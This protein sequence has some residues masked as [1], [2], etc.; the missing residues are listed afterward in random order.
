MIRIGSLF[1]GAGGLD[2]AVEALF[3][4]CHVVWQAEIDPHA[5]K[6]LAAHY[7][8]VPNL[9]DV[10]L[11]DWG[12]LRAPVDVLC[13]G[14][15]CQDVSQAGLRAG[16][17]GKRSGL[18]SEVVR[19]I[20]ALKPTA[21]VVENVRGLLSSKDK[22]TGE[23][24]IDV[25]LDG[26]YQ[27][28]YQC[29]WMV[30]SAS[31]IGAPHRRDR[32]FIV[33]SRDLGAEHVR[34]DTPKAAVSALL[35]T[36]TVADNKRGVDTASGGARPS[37]SKRARGLNNVL[38]HELDL[39]PLLP[40]PLARDGKGTPGEGYNEGNL[41]TEI[42]ALLPTPNASDGSGGGMDP[43]RAGHSRQLIDSVLLYGS[44]E[45]GKYEPA[46]RRWEGLSRPAPYPV[47]PNKNGKPRLVAAFSEW[48][49][50][51]PAG[52]VTDLDIARVH[53]LKIIGNGVVA[54]QAEAA[55]R[56]LDLPSLFG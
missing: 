35:P 27:L 50:G 3:E 46:V 33:A 21:V 42:T 30:L 29:R 20:A 47:E 28:G 18:W 40:S 15:P 39:L 5:S 23:K 41:I 53:Q 4:D 17:T 16:L 19:A 2:V 49:M 13:A 25:V 22:E 56:L 12:A 34:T 38:A 1:S 44:P 45:W 48:M 36:P 9:G 51:W 52:W 37:G 55:L 10:S 54:H 31:A 32:V 11:V 6:V 8:G 14:F 24:A 43:R 7:P 26:F